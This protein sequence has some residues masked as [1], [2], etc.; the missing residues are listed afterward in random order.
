MCCFRSGD[1]NK[2]WRCSQGGAE[3]KRQAEAGSGSLLIGTLR[4]IWSESQEVRGGCWVSSEGSRKEFLSLDADS[5][6]WRNMQG[7]SIPKGYEL[8]MSEV[9]CRPHHLG[10]RCFS[11]SYLSC[12]I[13]QVG[14][15]WKE[16]WYIFLRPLPSS[17]WG[18]F[19]FCWVGGFMLRTH[20]SWNGAGFY[21]MSCLF[22][23]FWA[24]QASLSLMEPQHSDIK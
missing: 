7:G 15:C 12:N 11:S 13:K 2:M 10:T 6:S 21:V 16:A 1:S 20:P 3:W 17:D 19:L 4:F 8:D 23:P 18:W 22:A 5:V 24:V 9:A 14:V